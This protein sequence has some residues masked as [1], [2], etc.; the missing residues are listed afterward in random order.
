LRL[1]FART[2]EETVFSYVG[3]DTNISVA[4][5]AHARGDR[6]LFDTPQ[7]AS[8]L[9]FARTREETGNHSF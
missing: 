7:F 8:W 9:R 6:L 1:R 4:L 5:R 3:D 2:R